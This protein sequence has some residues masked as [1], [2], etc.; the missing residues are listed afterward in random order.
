MITSLDR[1][2]ARNIAKIVPE[3][4]FITSIF[5]ILD[6]EELRSNML[7]YITENNNLNRGKLLIKAVELCE[8][9]GR[10]GVME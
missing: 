8:V 1:E 10:L 9:A 5:S 4:I 2:L 7:K 3:E 6:T